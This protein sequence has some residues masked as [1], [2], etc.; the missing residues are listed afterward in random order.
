MLI[1]DSLIGKI[2]KIKDVPEGNP[3]QNCHT[4]LRLR[5]MELGMYS[6]EMIEIAG[7]RLGLWIVNIL[8]DNGSIL[9]KITMRD[10]EIT[11]I[12][13]EDEECRVKVF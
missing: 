1:D 11:R 7:H 5:I 3:C 13:L 6:G 9:S 2:F 10:E 8:S 4:C 12:I